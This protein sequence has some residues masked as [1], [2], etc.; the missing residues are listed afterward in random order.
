V[1]KVNAFLVAVIGYYQ[2]L[3]QRLI[4]NQLRVDKI[5]V[6]LREVVAQPVRYYAV[7]QP[8]HAFVAF[9]ALVHKV[10][11]LA[12]VFK[13]GKLNARVGHVALQVVELKYVLLAL[14]RAGK[15]VVAVFAVELVIFHLALVVALQQNAVVLVLEH[16]E[17]N[18]T[19]YRRWQVV[20]YGFLVARFIVDKGHFFAIDN[21]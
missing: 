1:R 2:R 18:V 11:H 21:Q 7:F 6:N 17:H 20:M 8:H 15:Q 13:V 9:A 19:V 16:L 10:E 3:F 4:V 12:L 14:Y 5:T